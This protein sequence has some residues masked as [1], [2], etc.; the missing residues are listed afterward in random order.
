M[1]A[2]IILDQDNTRQDKAISHEGSS[3]SGGKYKACPLMLRRRRR[4]A[5]KGSFSQSTLGLNLSY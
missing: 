5:K 3:R 2:L 1:L 4:L